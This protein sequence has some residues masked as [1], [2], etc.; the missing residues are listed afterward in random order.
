MGARG[1]RTPGRSRQKGRPSTRR[2]K[3][4]PTRQKS[5]PSARPREP[6]DTPGSRR[7]RGAERGG[8]DPDPRRALQSGN[9]PRA[10]DRRRSPP[11]SARIALHRGRTHGAARKEMRPRSQ[12]GPALDGIES[13]RPWNWAEDRS[14]PR[15]LQERRAPL[16]SL[17]VHCPSG[18]CAGA[19]GLRAGLA[20]TRSRGYP[21]TPA[22]RGSALLAAPLCG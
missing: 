12:E 10:A 18:P 22:V 1:G 20:A 15:V 4:R 21:A 9:P 2:T 11:R 16:C 17:C 13:C 6:H 5:A 19:Q 14:R 3:L 7:E 8:G